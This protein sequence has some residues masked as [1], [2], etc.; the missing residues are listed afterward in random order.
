[1]SMLIP[2]LIWGFKIWGDYLLYFQEWSRNADGSM[3]PER[4][5]STRWLINMA[6]PEWQFALNGLSLIICLTCIWFVCWKSRGQRRL[7]PP[8][9]TASIASVQFWFPYMHMYDSIIV[10]AAIAVSLKS[11]A[12]SKL[13][14]LSGCSDKI[15]HAVV[16]AYPFIGVG[17]FLLMPDFAN[18]F[19]IPFVF[20]NALLFASSM[21][22]FFNR[23]K[24]H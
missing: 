23:L 20:A 24:N 21:G 3:H 12:P 13:G 14:L 4:Q 7:I 1:M 17:G 9:F 11:F 19:N 15:F 5:P 2:S 22:C 6:P 10:W 8:A 18:K 16:L